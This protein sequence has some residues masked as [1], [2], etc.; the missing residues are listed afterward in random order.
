MTT[1]TT[2]P[3]KSMS[4]REP[5]A[6]LLYN[7][8]VVDIKPVHDTLRIFRVL[9]DR[10][11][12]EFIPGQYIGLGLGNWE[13]GD[14]YETP[15]ADQKKRII[16]RAYSISWPILD[17]QNHL[18]RPGEMLPL[19]FYVTL[20]THTQPHPQ[21]LTPRLFHLK[22]GDRLWIGSRARGS[23]TLRRANPTDHFVFVATGTGEA[24]HNA[25]IAQ[26]LSKGHTGPITNLACVRYRCDLGYLHQHRELER[27]YPNYRYVPLTTRE[28]EN[29]NPQRHDF[30]GKR[31]VQDVVVHWSANLGDDRPLDPKTTQVYLCGNPDMIGMPQSI[32]HAEP[33]YPEKTGMVELLQ[34]QGFRLDQPLLA[35]NIHV[36]KYW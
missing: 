22:V 7:A 11:P 16:Q 12:L 1:P 15:P 26:L 31:Y 20:V 19:E 6:P 23:Y 27:R 32:G 13:A 8:A 35:G 21:S 24:P 17:D 30:V 14:E 33:I 25:M 5:A 29:V 28:P 4:K 3:I 36:E 10:S 34:R 9:A 18:L 2:T